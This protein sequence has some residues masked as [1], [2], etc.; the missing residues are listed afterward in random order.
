MEK[1]LK[2]DPIGDPLRGPPPGDYQSSVQLLGYPHVTESE[3]NSASIPEVAFLIQS[4][5]FPLDA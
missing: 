5:N 3:F 1:R 2:W 4:R